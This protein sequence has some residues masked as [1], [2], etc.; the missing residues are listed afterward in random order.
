MGTSK[1]C[2][3]NLRGQD[4]LRRSETKTDRYWDTVQK[5]EGRIREAFEGKRTKKNTIDTNRLAQLKERGDL[6]RRENGAKRTRRIAK[7][8]PWRLW[9]KKGGGKLDLDRREETSRRKIE[10]VAVQI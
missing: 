2:S 6:N 1:L 5:S 3:S 4:R 7:I 8:H 10:W 9:E